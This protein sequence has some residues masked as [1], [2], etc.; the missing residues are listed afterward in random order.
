MPRR[1]RNVFSFLLLEI[2]L[3]RERMYLV[4]KLLWRPGEPKLGLGTKQYQDIVLLSKPY[5]SVAATQLLLGD[6]TIDID[7]DLIA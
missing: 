5:E 2:N 4:A 1:F 3:Y 7:G 6:H